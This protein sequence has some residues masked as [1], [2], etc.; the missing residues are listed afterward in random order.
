MFKICLSFVLKQFI[1]RLPVQAVG[2]LTFSGRILLTYLF[3]E[4]TISISLSPLNLFFLS[5]IWY[6]FALKS[7]KWGTLKTLLQR[8]NVNYSSEKHLKDELKH[9]RKTAN[10]INYPY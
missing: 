1:N 10:E 4:L 6:C 7:R 5:F 8:K 2:T 9:I 3:I